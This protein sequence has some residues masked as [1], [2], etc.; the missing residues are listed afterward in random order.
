MEN[1]KT[2]DYYV[3][4]IRRI[5]PLDLQNIDDRIII[6]WINLTRAVWLKNEVNKLN[7]VSYQFKQR[8]FC[9]IKPY[10]QSL[11]IDIPTAARILR[12]TTK[13][14]KI[15]SFGH[16]DGI[17]SIKNAKVLSESYNYVT[18]EQAIYSGNGKLNNRDIFVFMNEDYMYIKLQKENPKIALLTHLV[19]EL[20]AENPLEVIKLNEDIDIDNNFMKDISYPIDDIL[21]T[22]MREEVA[23]NG[24][25]TI[26]S[27]KDENS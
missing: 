10:D 11:V 13:I 14:P 20:Y 24:L 7:D 25:M 15:L 17:V 6:R 16:S 23:K 18:K 22:Y 5:L 8:L 19:I 9:E 21:W 26:Q 4:E 27:T 1:T 2:L 12:S 3:F